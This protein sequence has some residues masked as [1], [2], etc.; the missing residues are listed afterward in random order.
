MSA[1]R[2]S[3]SGHRIGWWKR[4]FGGSTPRLHKPCRSRTVLGVESLET[5]EVPAVTTGLMNGMLVISGDQSD[6]NVRAVYNGDRSFILVQEL[7]STN[8]FKAN[9]GAFSS[10][11]VHEV[12]FD[13]MDGNDRFDGSALDVRID[14]HGGKGND[15]LLGGSAN[16]TLM[17][18]PGNDVLDGGGGVN[19]ISDPDALTA[20]L[21][22]ATGMLHIG[23]SHADKN[24]RLV[25]NGDRSFILVQE[26]NPNN[27][28]KAN[29]GAFATNLIQGIVF[30]G[31][32]AK[33]R[34]DASQMTV[35]VMAMGFGGHD[36][37]IGG[38]A[39]D[40]L[41]GGDGTDVLIGNG[42]MNELIDI[43]APEASLSG[44]VV[45]IQGYTLGDAVRAIEVGSELRVDQINLTTFQVVRTL[46]RFNLADVNEIHFDGQGGN[47][48]L[49]VHTSR[50]VVAYG[51]QGND[52]LTG[53]SNRDSLYGGEGNDSL[54]GDTGNDFLRGDD[55]N[56]TLRG[57]DGNDTLWGDAGDDVIHGE[58][59]A[60]S[61]RG[62]N[63]NDTITGGIGND[64][65]F[66]DGGDDRIE[67]GDGD[68]SLM[69]GSG[70][71]ELIGGDGRDNLR[72]E[73][74]DDI[75]RGNAGRDF[76]LGGDG[77][78]TLFRAADDI[79][80]NGDAGTNRIYG[81]TGLRQTD[82]QLGQTGVL[83]VSLDGNTL[84]LNGPTG[85]GFE[86]VGNW[87]RFDLGGGAELFRG[88]GD[89]ILRSALG[90]IS[91][92]AP[93]FLPLE[94]RTASDG[95]TF[96]GE[97]TDVSWASG[98]A[99]QSQ[100]NFAIDTTS[101]TNPFY[102]LSST[103]IG[104][105]TPSVRWG[106][107]LGS[108]LGNVRVPLANAVPYLYFT[109]DTG[110]SISFGAASGSTSP[111]V[112]LTVA[113]D[114]A[115][116][117]LFARFGF[118]GPVT[119]GF[120]VGNSRNGYIPFEPEARPTQPTEDIYGHLYFQGNVTVPVIDS[121]SLSGNVNVVYDLDANNDGV[122]LG[123]DPETVIFEGLV[124]EP[125]EDIRVGV[126]G[127]VDTSYGLG[128]IASLSVRIGQGT[129][130]YSPFGGTADNPARVAFR[131]ILA[132]NPFEGTF[133]EGFN[134]LSP[135]GMIDATVTGDLNGSLFIPREFFGHIFYA[136]GGSVPG[137][138]EA[139]SVSLTVN[140]TDDFNSSN[141]FVEASVGFRDLRALGRV[142]LTGKIYF[143][144]DFQLTGA[145][146]FD[147]DAGIV[148]I[149]GGVSITFSRF[150][151]VVG[152]VAEGT[153]S[154]A[155]GHEGY[156]IS[157]EVR[158]RFEFTVDSSGNVRLGGSGRATGRVEGFGQSENF[159]ESFDIRHDGFDIAL[160]FVP[161][162]HVRF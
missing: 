99:A 37:L 152:L 88:T 131:G 114:P 48:F 12:M 2:Q 125:T 59:G 31:T 134:P 147:F 135:Q 44:G 42:G 15:T 43:R 140:Y 122:L 47:D 45:R 78:D 84:T 98:D 23:G 55:G 63:G 160:P 60:D 106:V 95:V 89:L 4:L 87:Q 19:S 149:N 81:L 20:E 28:F 162:L 32:D 137:G 93:T 117:A 86:I 115:D 112:D 11:S 150:N 76:L 148:D 127:Q 126:N 57:G 51:W 17:G 38:S 107:A 53:G 33:D 101:P 3:K 21:D 71:D 128:P 39:D 50:R 102:A 111:S 16:D 77:N 154:V 72:G 120:G 69:G 75:L 151:G 13:G 41:N 35:P 144:G 14:A 65:V 109:I 108:E 92:T 73:S 124:S 79:I 143:D 119:F 70:R 158:L 56:D 74:G 113:F 142:S 141:D 29:L 30:S 25:F 116:P 136:Q 22:S 54:V 52:T 49:D 82:A 90:D 8:A 1:L 100:T 34:L 145:T 9:L 157:V 129:L 138:F 80:V 67:G 103:G 58:D 94:F 10:N 97:V 104:L 24:V 146:G 68:D 155:F 26:L 161:D 91:F 61:I 105:Q 123:I 159:S 96:G 110:Y 139:D 18:G 46:G 85:H 133:L 156:S 83:L 36:T 130:M 5:R 66:G 153:T 62:G 132:P 118:S 40:V 6:N 64:T 121:I 27:S 7:T